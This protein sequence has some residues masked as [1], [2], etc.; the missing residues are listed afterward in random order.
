MRLTD[1]FLEI[2]LQCLHQLPATGPETLVETRVSILTTRAFKPTVSSLASCKVFLAEVF[3][4]LVYYPQ[5]LLQQCIG[6]S[7]G[8]GKDLN[9]YFLLW[10]MIV[11]DQASLL[12]NAMP[13]SLGIAMLF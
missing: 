4:V 7:G 2:Y 13:F 9:R 11:K 10:G 1:V 3:S 12:S 5:P 8:L 6:T